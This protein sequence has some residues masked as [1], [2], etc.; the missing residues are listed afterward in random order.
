MKTDREILIIEP[1]VGYMLKVL[2]SGKTITHFKNEFGHIRHGNYFD[3]LN[4]VQGPIPPMTTYN[5]GIVT[6]DN[7]PRKTDCDFA[8]LLKSGPSLMI[9]FKNCTSVY[10]HIVDNDVPDNIYLKAVL[11]E[12]SLRMHANNYGLLNERE[13]LI[14]VINKLCSLK[15]ISQTDIE[16]IHKGRVFINMIKHFD[17]Q[18][19]TWADGISAFN[20]AYEIIEKHELKI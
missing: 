2:K 17:N 15:N 18:F 16:D 8:L 12:I 3:F 5:N 19:P 6:N 14:D 1:A 4:L 20:N 10:G 7:T 9:F 11:F 13:K